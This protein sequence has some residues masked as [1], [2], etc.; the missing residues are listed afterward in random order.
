M[1]PTIGRIGV[2]GSPGATPIE[3]EQY[4]YVIGN[5]G[6]VTERG[7]RTGSF[8]SFTS[9]SSGI[10]MSVLVTTQTP[11]QIDAVF[12]ADLYG[13]NDVLFRIG[14]SVGILTRTGVGT[15]TTNDD[16]AVALGFIHAIFDGSEVSIFTADAHQ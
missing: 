13:T 2:I 6:I 15:Y 3:W 11:N 16:V 9:S 4:T 14:G 7:L 12:S 1:Q 8:G 10:T 5:D